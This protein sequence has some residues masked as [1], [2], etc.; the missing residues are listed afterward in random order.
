MLKPSQTA[1]VPFVSVEN[2]MRLV[3]HIGLE[4]MLKDLAAEIEADFLR[5]PLFDKTPRVAS[6]SE[7]RNALKSCSPSSA[8]AAR[9]MASAS[10]GVHTHDSH[11]RAS[12]GRT[13]RLRM[14]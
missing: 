6:H 9:C 1:Y 5:W 4:T 8:C 3:H 11:C 10:S 12:A 14:R 13:W 7:D 2:M